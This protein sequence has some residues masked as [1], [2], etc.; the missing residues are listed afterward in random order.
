MFFAPA[1]AD[2]PIKVIMESR[3]KRQKNLD[4]LS[5]DKKGSPNFPFC[6]VVILSRPPLYNQAVALFPLPPASKRSFCN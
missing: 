5:E 1:D 3:E 2:R 4:F 6:K